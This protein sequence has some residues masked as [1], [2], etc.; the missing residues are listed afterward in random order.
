MN[1]TIPTLMK[2]FSTAFDEY[3]F[4]DNS[5]KLPINMFRIGIHNFKFQY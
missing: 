2:D 3:L 4:K 1:F 5:T